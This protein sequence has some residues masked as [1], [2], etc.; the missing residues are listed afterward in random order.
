MNEVKILK[1]I[2]RFSLIYLVAII[3]VGTIL[4]LLNIDSNSGAK[5]GALLAAVVMTI[6]KFLKD[7]KRIPNKQEKSK[8]VWGSLIASFIVSSLVVVP[9][10]ILS[11][12]F[13]NIIKLISG[14]S[15]KYFLAAFIFIT[16][17]YYL[18]LTFFYGSFSKSLYKNMKKKGEI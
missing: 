7:N 4:I 12:E 18:L 17:I 16:V 11:G 1:Y 6:D 9:L 10:L 8:L 14:E 2:L 15:S 5:I 3:L 13:S